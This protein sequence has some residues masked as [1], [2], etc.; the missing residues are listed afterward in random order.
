MYASLSPNI[1]QLVLERLVN[2]GID[3]G[4]TLL[5]IPDLAN[6]DKK[7]GNKATKEVPAIG[8]ASVEYNNRRSNPKSQS[9]LL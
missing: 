9:F 2:E 4:H 3:Y 6:R 7:A 5:A 1:I 8:V